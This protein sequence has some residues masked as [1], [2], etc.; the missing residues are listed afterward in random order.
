MLEEASRA[1][2]SYALHPATLILFILLIRAVMKTPHAS[3]RLLISIVW[4]RYVMQAY[5][6]IT[7]IS[8][9][10]VSINALGS[11][12]VCCVGAFVL[13]RQIGDLGRYPIILSLIAVV[14]ASGLMNGA[15]EPMIETVL[16]WGYFLI[17]MLAVQDCIRRDGDIRI[18]GLLLWAFAPPLVYQALSI[19]L[20][21]GKAGEN[22]G[23][24]SFI[25]GYNHEAAFSIVLVTCFAVASL[26]PKLNPVVR[27]FLLVV[28]LA[29][30]F[31][32]NYRTSFI[33]I[34]PI[35][36]GY[37]VFGA[38]RAAKPAR[39]ILISLVGF[40]VMAGGFVAA[41]VLLAE[42]L[43]DVAIAAGETDDLIRPTEEFTVADQKLLSGRLYIWNR[44][45]EGYG[46][47]DDKTL[48][49]G[50]G[51]DSWVEPFG[52]YAHNTIVSYLYEFGLVGATLIVLVW[53]AMLGRAL[54]I[55]DWAL[56]GQ[57]VC[58]HIGFFL[59]NMATMPFWQ[60][61]GLILYG[62]LC[63][64]TVCMSPSRVRK[65]MI[66]HYTP[67]PKMTKTPDWW[68]DPARPPELDKSQ[69]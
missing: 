9:G 43:N 15:V 61:E 31:A 25:G 64:Y 59:L 66:R 7:Y 62:V 44:Y 60:I 27:L 48:L 37:F 69:A 23:S 54:S 53:L 28:C 5:H 20:G 19:G 8:F 4:L 10:G 35:A 58:V 18:L 1:L 2:P 14:M 51:P 32:A 57:L 13:R 63:G 68:K 40:I 6:E 45:L 65:P 24:I 39:R 41:N 21:V 34:A 38:A 55:R 33:A 46:A 29:G 17:V 22:D 42:R 26:A 52:V 67:P 3:G 50:H 12:A 16:K 56:R 36:F 49:L 11:L 30:I 47:G